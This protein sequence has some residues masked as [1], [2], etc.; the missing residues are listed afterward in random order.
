MNRIATFYILSGFAECF[1]CII[2]IHIHTV[3][4]LFSAPFSKERIDLLEKSS[5]LSQ[6]KCLLGW[7]GQD[8][9]IVYTQL[10]NLLRMMNN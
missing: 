6:I 2:K 4:Y 3:R 5:F 9:S 7:Y 10:P 8:N 1:K